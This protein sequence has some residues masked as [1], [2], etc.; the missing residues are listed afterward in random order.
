LNKQ[1]EERFKIVME[2]FEKICCLI[3]AWS[4]E[5]IEISKMKKTE[6]AIESLIVT[7][8]SMV[9]KMSGDEEAFRIFIATIVNT[10]YQLPF[11]KE[12]SCKEKKSDTNE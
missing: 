4:E 10:F 3:N 11:N 6:I 8:G 5:N 7:I 9:N 12:P 2:L 1:K